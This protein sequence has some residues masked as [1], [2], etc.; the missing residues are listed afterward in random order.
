[1]P[2]EAVSKDGKKIELKIKGDFDFNEHAQ[3]RNSYCNE[4]PDADYIINMESADS[5]DSSALGMLL[6]LREHA[7]SDS[8]KI[9]IVNTPSQIK[10]VFKNSNFDSL[11]KIS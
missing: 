8:A 9:T 11:F 4:S 10:Q 3:F 2:I 1:M 6:M 7:G 5:L